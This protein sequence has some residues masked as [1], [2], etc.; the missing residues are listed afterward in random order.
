[1]FPLVIWQ[2]SLV[3]LSFEVFWNCYIA[4]VC[5]DTSFEDR[6]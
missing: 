5:L 2:F 4:F 3:G 1:M 6:H